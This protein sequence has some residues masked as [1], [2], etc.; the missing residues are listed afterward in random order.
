M[1]VELKYKG[2]ISPDLEIQ[3]EELQEEQ[4]LLLEEE[5]FAPEKEEAEVKEEKDEEISDPAVLYLRDIGSFP[6]ITYEREVE[7]A[8]RIE[9]GRAQVQE[10]VSSSSAVRL[11]PSQIGELTKKLKE[12]FARWT[13]LEQ[14]VELARDKNE[15]GKIVSQ[16]REIE[17]AIGLPAEELKRLVGL[18]LEGEGKVNLAKKEFI[19]ANLRFVV[20]V[21]KKYV[22]RG[23]PF[24]DAVQEGNIG[25]MRAVEKFDYRVGYRFATYAS[26]WIRQAITRGIVDSR[27]TIRVPV[28]RFEMRKKL[29]RKVRALLQSLGREPLPEEIAAA[30]GLSVHDVLRTIRM[31][32]EPVSLDTPIGEEARLGDF[33]EDRNVPQPL[34]EVIWADRQAKIRKV[35]ACLSPREETVLRLHFGIGE[36]RDYTLE[37]LGERFS[38]TRERVRQIEERALRALRFPGKKV[39]RAEP[40]RPFR[41]S[42]RQELKKA[43][44][45]RTE[46]HWS[47]DTRCLR[48]RWTRS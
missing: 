18:I 20:S 43:Y 15:C 46:Y 21:A 34:D 13:V 28:H 9:E 33:F 3:T 25:L 6:L 42:A 16:M 37:E 29:M 41:I 17:N 38:M 1:R 4:A 35:L 10:A 44:Q 45:G 24:L 36:P 7:L 48:V 2:D 11:S 26:W 39:K 47:E 40:R 22:K 32:L 12:F 27:H 23:A 8:K 5:P 14:K 30:M 31:G 19:E